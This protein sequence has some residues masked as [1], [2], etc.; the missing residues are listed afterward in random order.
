MKRRTLLAAAGAGVIVAAGPAGGQELQKLRLVSA[1]VD[2]FKTVQYAVKAGIFRKYGL[3]VETTMVN[4]G[5]AGAAALVG[6]AADIAGISG[7][8]LFQAHLRGVPMEYLSPSILL[9]SDHVTTQTLVAKNS[10]VKTGKDLTGKVIGSSSV[11]D[12]NSAATLAWIDQTGGDAKSVKLIEVPASTAAAVLE[13]G[14]ADAVT[15]NE[16]AVGQVLATGNARAIAHP[17]DAISKRLEASGWAAMK[18]VVEKNPDPFARFARA[19]HESGLYTNTHNA[20]TVDM[21]AASTGVPPEV[22]AKSIRMVDPEYLDVA[23]FQPLI[24]ALAKFGFLAASFPAAEIISS[25][26]LKPPG[27]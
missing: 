24:D 25:A 22:V 13:S 14:R 20:E 8:T 5:A 11:S 16:P 12:M 23:N 10:P 26:A 15:L 27:R 21:V 19:M 3:E 2:A 7:L 17:Y 9:T 6:G 18:P 4:S 1:P